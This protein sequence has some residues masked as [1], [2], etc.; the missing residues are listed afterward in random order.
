MFQIA[1]A[2]LNCRLFGRSEIGDSQWVEASRSKVDKKVREVG[3][4][5]SKSGE[6]LHCHSSGGFS[7][8][9]A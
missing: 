8:F 9:V 4:V 2:P 3:T 7:R 6:T 5:V 1:E